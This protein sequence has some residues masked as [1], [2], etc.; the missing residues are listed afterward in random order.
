MVSW[1]KSG[2]EIAH[3]LYNDDSLNPARSAA[4]VEFAFAQVSVQSAHANLG[5][6]QLDL[7]FEEIQAFMK[8]QPRARPLET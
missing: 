3:E 8:F 6:P 1:G 5:H 7:S 2:V 4:F